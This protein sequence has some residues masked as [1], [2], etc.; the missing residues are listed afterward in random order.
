HTR[1]SR[2]WSSD[3]C[4]SDLGRQVSAQVSQGSPDLHAHIIGLGILNLTLNC[5]GTQAVVA[6]DDRLFKT[7]FD[8]TQLGDGQLLAIWGYYFQGAQ[9]VTIQRAVLSFHPGDHLH[10]TNILAQLGHG[11]AIKLELHLSRY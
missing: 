11:D 10:G 1:F 4:S 9:A 7:D 6:F 8:V 2:D 3:V 5:Q